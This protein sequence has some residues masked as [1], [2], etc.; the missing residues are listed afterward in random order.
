[1]GQ[2]LMERVVS[3]TDSSA[4]Q[5]AV[6]KSWAAVTLKIRIRP[7]TAAH[8]PWGAQRDKH[9]RNAPRRCELSPARGGVLGRHSGIHSRPQSR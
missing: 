5:I 2:L 6:G 9:H 3:L 8:A 7:S 4:A 1:M